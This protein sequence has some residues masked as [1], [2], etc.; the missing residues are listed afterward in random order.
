MKKLIIYASLLCL[1]NQAQAGWFDW[2]TGG[3]DKEEVAPAAVEEVAA[4]D[5]AGD[6]ATAVALGLIPDIT[7]SFGVTETQAG[8][9]V[10]SLLQVA[11]GTLSDDEF[12]TLSAYIPDSGDMLSMAPVIGGDS[13]MGSVLKTAGQYS[14][15]M[16][17]AGQVAAQF[18]AL[19][20]DPALA[21]QYMV[22]IQGFLQSTG[23]KAA[24]DLFTKGVS[25]LA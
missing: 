25:A 10:G 11:Q 6:A 1:A 4:A 21:A 19:G 15:S 5:L 8:G 16:K 13:A 24:V 22:K 20:L 18:E 14:E 12:S 7:N 17:M 2:L 9:G 3:D 23:G